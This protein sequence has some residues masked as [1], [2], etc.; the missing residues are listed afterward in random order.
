MATAKTLKNCCPATSMTVSMR[1]LPNAKAK[2]EK[3]KST[4]VG[5]DKA[6]MVHAEIKDS[7]AQITLRIVS[8]LISATYDKADACRWRRRSGFRGQRPLDLRP[9]YPLARSE[10]ETRGDR[11]RT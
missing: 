4:F 9:R 8:Q 3:V 7:E 6:D 11:I 1:R 10:L 5:I 2:G